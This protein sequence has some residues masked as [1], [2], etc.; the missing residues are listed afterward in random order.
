MENIN[1][2]NQPPTPPSNSE[3]GKYK[4]SVVLVLLFAALA[5][6]VY[7]IFGASTPTPAPEPSGTPPAAQE[8]QGSAAMQ[9]SAVE[10]DLSAIDLNSLDSELADIG[11]ELGQ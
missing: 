4:M 10:A 6:A 9:A 2:S 11:K 7:F 1:S 3:H 8:N 5:A